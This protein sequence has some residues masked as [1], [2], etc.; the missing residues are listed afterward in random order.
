MA[1][2]KRT[3]QQYYSRRERGYRVTKFPKGY[4]RWGYPIICGVLCSDGTE[5][6]NPSWSGWRRCEYHQEEHDRHLAGRKIEWPQRLVYEVTP[7]PPMRKKKRS[8]AKKASELELVIAEMIDPTI[9]KEMTRE[10]SVNR[11]DQ[12]LA[13]SVDDI[14]IHLR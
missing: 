8:G 12:A 13:Q 5:C 11:P 7:A 10:R 4:D 9:Q 1:T 6:P 2:S 14:P 3:G